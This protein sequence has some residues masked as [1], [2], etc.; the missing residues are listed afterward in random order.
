MGAPLENGTTD[1]IIIG[2]TGNIATGK[3]TVSQY[4]QQKGAYT[5]DADEVAHRVTEPGQDAYRLIVE[6]FGKNVLDQTGRIDRKSLAAIVFNDADKLGRLEQ[7]V[8]PAVFQSI[9]NEIELN[10]PA[11][12]ILEAI[13]L[14][15]AGSMATLCDEIWVVVADS[16]EQ[17]RRARVNRGMPVA[18]TQR[19]SSMQSPQAVKMN[20]ADIVIYN[21]G[22]PADLHLQLDHIWD[23]LHRRYAERLRGSAE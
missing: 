7:I 20:Q 6:E 8:H 23:E 18:E 17:I 3:T 11:V 14:L 19:R 12:A 9:Y 15:E 2:L 13:K 10:E 22:S 1:S 16:D 21:D 4:L 5:I